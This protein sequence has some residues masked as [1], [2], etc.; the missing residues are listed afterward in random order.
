MQR[1]TCHLWKRFKLLALMLTYL[2]STHAYAQQLPTVTGAVTS[3]EDGNG[4]SGITITIKG[5]T[6][7]ATTNAVGKFFIKVA[8]GK[9]LVFSGIGFDT[10]EIVVNLLR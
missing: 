8:T 10:R 9:T 4:L 7:G 6:G 5:S 1:F 2:L 3:K